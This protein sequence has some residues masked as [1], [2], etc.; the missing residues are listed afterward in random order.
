MCEQHVKSPAVR[1]HESYTVADLAK[2][3]KHPWQGFAEWADTRLPPCE[4]PGPAARRNGYLDLRG[5]MRK[6]GGLKFAHGVQCRSYPGVLF[7]VD[8]RIVSHSLIE[9]AYEAVQGRGAF[10]RLIATLGITKTAVPFGDVLQFFKLKET[11]RAAL[12]ETAA[13]KTAEGP[14]EGRAD[15]LTHK[16]I[17]RLQRAAWMLDGPSGIE[18]FFWTEVQTRL[19]ELLPGFQAL[20]EAIRSSRPLT[21]NEVGE[22]SGFLA[23]GGLR[24]TLLT[25]PSGAVTAENTFGPLWARLDED[26]ATE[27]EKHAVALVVPIAYQL[28]VAWS[29]SQSWPR[30]IA[31]CRNPSCRREFYSG[32]REAVACPKKPHERVTSP[33]KREWDKYKRWLTKTGHDPEL[34]WENADLRRQYLGR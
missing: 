14:S 26:L 2:M 11:V 21:E 4:W 28:A 23:Y 12:A 18:K 32:H 13:K 33:C 29:G 5:V 3:A 30:F 10:D 17:R 19:R 15:P 25:L 6:R 8:W 27:E 22:I 7:K 20:H 1:V 24:S 31:T 16:C 34:A 9:R